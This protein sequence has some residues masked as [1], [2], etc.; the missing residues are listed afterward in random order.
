MEEDEAEGEATESHGEQM[1]GSEMLLVK[2]LSWSPLALPL[3]QGLE[4]LWSEPED[5]LSVLR[6]GEG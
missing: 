1:E 4:E 3:K 6:A 2:A 5:K